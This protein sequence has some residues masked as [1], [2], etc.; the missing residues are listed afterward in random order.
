MRP[1]DGTEP[2]IS[3]FQLGS[4]SELN[5]DNQSLIL[6][7]LFPCWWD[8]HRVGRLDD[9]SSSLSLHQH[10]IMERNCVKFYRRKIKFKNLEK[11]GS[12]F[13]GASWFLVTS[14]ICEKYSCSRYCRSSSGLASTHLRRVSHSNKSCGL[15]SGCDSRM[16]SRRKAVATFIS[17]N[18][19]ISLLWQ[20]SIR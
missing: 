10:I 12:G 16:A 14:S 2:P 15:R 9:Q 4:G 5:R 20:K 18:K 19:S 13:F 8:R 17:S 3:T 1:K 11:M 7:L 6:C